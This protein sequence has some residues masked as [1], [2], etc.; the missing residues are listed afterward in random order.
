MVGADRLRQ[1]IFK[2]ADLRPGSEEVGAEHLLDLGY[3]VVRHLLAP[4][5][6]QR[7]PNRGAAVHS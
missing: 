5:R 4:V 1:S 7:I 6:Q 2:F 3:I